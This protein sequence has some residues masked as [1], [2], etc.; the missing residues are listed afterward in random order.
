[1][2]SFIILDQQSSGLGLSGSVGSAYCQDEA[3]SEGTQET[4]KADK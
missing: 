2:Q 1:M 3:E 4:Q